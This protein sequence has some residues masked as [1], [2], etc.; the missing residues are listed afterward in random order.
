VSQSPL[1]VRLW[2]SEPLEPAY[3]KASIIDERGQAVGTAPASVDKSD[4]KLLRVPL[5]KLAA[6]KYTVRYR[7]L[8]VDGHVIDYGYSFVIKATSTGN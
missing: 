8:S 4:A 1:E 7:V 6:G 3:S 2:F 5:P